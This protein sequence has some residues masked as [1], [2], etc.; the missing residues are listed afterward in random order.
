MLSQ[1]VFLLY[2]SKN[3]LF[4]YNHPFT[5]MASTWQSLKSIMIYIISK[6]LHCIVVLTM[7]KLVDRSSMSI[8]KPRYN[9]GP[10]LSRNSVSAAIAFQEC[11]KSLPSIGAKSWNCCSNIWHGWC[12]NS[13]HFRS[14][15]GNSKTITR[16][17]NSASLEQGLFCLYYNKKF[18]YSI[19][20]IKKCSLSSSYPACR[21]VVYSIR[22]VHCSP[23]YVCTSWSEILTEP[24]TTYAI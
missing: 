16:V 15:R 8:N 2:H 11:I 17:S 24:H 1:K 19:Y 20:L 23:S 4:N 7:L 6:D 22:G 18:F 21:V 10:L 13:C 5:Q 14:K 3:I 12:L 9:I